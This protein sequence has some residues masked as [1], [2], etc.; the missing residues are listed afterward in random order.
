[1]TVHLRFY[2][3]LNDYLPE[4]K[5]K[6]T[7]TE[8][9]PANTTIMEVLEFMGVPLNA[10]DLI[11]VD[12]RSVDPAHIPSDH[13][14]IAVY[15]VFESMDIGTVTR[16]RQE[17]L[18]RPRFIADPGLETLADR[19]R[20]CGFDA[21]CGT[22]YT[23][24]EIDAIAERERR[25]LLTQD[26]S[27]QRRTVRICRIREAAPDLQVQEVIRRLDLFRYVERDEDARG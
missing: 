1:M 11:L 2:E 21:G 9:F 23:A 20:H 14:R 5:R 12:G 25:I 24:A 18:R 8:Q 3:E 6:C 17:P 4:E 27:R 13:D 26:E 16:V 15:P 22:G 7:L 19:L 10:V